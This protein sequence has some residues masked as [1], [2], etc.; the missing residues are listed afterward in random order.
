MGK[1]PTTFDEWVAN[2]ELWRENV[3]FDAKW[4]GDFELKPLFDWDRAGETI[5]FG[6]YEGR[7][8]WENSTVKF[9]QSLRHRKHGS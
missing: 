7:Q 8:K 2:F 9:M 4:A 5:E 1:L 3:G 6:D